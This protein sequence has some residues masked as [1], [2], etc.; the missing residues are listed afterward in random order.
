VSRHAVFLHRE[1][2]AKWHVEERR[3]ALRSDTSGLE[4][5]PPKPEDSRRVGGSPSPCLLTTLEFNNLGRLA[6]D[7]AMR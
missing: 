7:V 2:D 3:L 6:A 4:Y 5:V 1:R